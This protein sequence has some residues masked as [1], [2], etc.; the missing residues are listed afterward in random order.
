VVGG[1]PEESQDRKLVYGSRGRR[2]KDAR[3]DK[4]DEVTH[5]MLGMREEKWY[6]VPQKSSC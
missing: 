2:G 6:V 5:H 4:K 1:T 3:L